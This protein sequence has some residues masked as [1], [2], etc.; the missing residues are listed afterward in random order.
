MAEDLT[1]QDIIIG[2]E[3]SFDNDLC[4]DIAN[5]SAALTSLSEI[6]I[7]LLAKGRQAKLARMK[8]QIFDSL[9]NYC[10]CL[11]S[12]TDNEKNESE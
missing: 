12:L 10:D 5:L 2:E 9:T 8:R 1:K 6:D 3:D 11:P 4:G 7:G